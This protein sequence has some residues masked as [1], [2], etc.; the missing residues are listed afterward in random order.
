MIQKC[1]SSLGEF[2]SLQDYDQV[3][4]HF[5]PPT[6]MIHWSDDSQ[7][8]DY[9][10]RFIT[11]QQFQDFAHIIIKS[12]ASVYSRLMYDWQPKIN[13]GMIKNDFWNNRKGFSFIQHSV[14][15]L[16]DAY[17][18]LSARACMTKKNDLVMKKK[19]NSLTI[20]WYLKWKKELFD[21]ILAILYVLEDQA[22]WSTEL[23]SIKF[24]ND[25]TSKHSIYVYDRFLIY[26]T[27]HHKA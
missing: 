7:T 11:L 12:A 25:S 17:L 5:N 19:W 27:R 1:L 14:N 15:R 18:Q 26:V 6:L 9:D 10:E 16:A 4:S 13:L 21:F 20:S 2:V 24:C 3:L 22:F 8:L 23:M